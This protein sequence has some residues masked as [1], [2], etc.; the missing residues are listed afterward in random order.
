M[1][2][3]FVGAAHARRV[4]GCRAILLVRDGHRRG[5]AGVPREVRPRPRAWSGP[6]AGRRAGRGGRAF[7]AADAR[8]HR[9]VVRRRRADPGVPRVAGPVVRRDQGA[10]LRRPALRRLLRRALPSRRPRRSSA[11]GRSTAYRSVPRTATRSSTRSP[12]STASAWSMVPSTCT[13]RSGATSPAWS[14]RSRPAWWPH[15]V[16]I[17]ECTTLGPGGRV[18]GAGRVWRASP[19]ADGV[20][21]SRF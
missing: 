7:D 2:G 8:G 6:R 10:G 4:A 12:S 1:F 19:A 21:V 20:V 14:P 9:R 16:A 11:A 18:V 13:P 15:G 17:D 3:G 5:V